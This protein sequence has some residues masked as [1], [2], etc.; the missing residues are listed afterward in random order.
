[1]CIS[2]AG[3]LRSLFQQPRFDIVRPMPH[4]IF[5][6][7]A[8]KTVAGPIAGVDEAGRGPLAGSVAV[9]AV[10]LNPADLPIGVDDSK[11]LTAA[12]REA[13]FD[14][15]LVKALA[16]SIAF[17]SADEIDQHNI[18]MA[19]LRAM[20][21]AVA[22]LHTRPRMVLVD[23]RDVP[24]GLALL[25]APTGPASLRRTAESGSSEFA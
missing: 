11:A 12:R 23:G 24:P 25:L 20:A 3:A 4:Y 5:E 17:A 6:S 8:L 13:L 2:G 1:M 10:I 19:T 9:A 15:I 14:L 16:V 21:R 7:R 22:A 18:R